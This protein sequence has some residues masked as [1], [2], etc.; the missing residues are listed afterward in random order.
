MTGGNSNWD[1]IAHSCNDFILNGVNNGDGEYEITPL[2][3]TTPVMVYCDMTTLGGGWTLVANHRDYV[4]LNLSD[5][6]TPTQY[7]VLSDDLWVS[8]LST[9]TEGMM[10]IDENNIVSMISKVKLDQASCQRLE[11]SQSLLDMPN[12][13][14]DETSGCNLLASDY[15]V[16]TLNSGQYGAALYNYSTRRFDV[17]GYPS[18]ISYISQNEL[19][20][21]IK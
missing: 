5:Y 3:R 16:I 2:T 17:W 12:L 18:N 19:M 10:F 7:N 11:E 8:I 15:S 21:F 4:S 13:W 1:G 14:H 6:V 20:Y 9:Y